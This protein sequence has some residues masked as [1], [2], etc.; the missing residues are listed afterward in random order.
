LKHDKFGFESSKN[1]INQE[2]NP[3]IFDFLFL[4][5]PA[6]GWADVVSIFA[7]NTARSWGAR[8]GKGIEHGTSLISKSI[9]L[10]LYSTSVKPAWQL[11]RVLFQHGL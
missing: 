11:S 8:L 2:L 3:K 7:I 4:R 10:D 9:V 5:L 1:R 6:D